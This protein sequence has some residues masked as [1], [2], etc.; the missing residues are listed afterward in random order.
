MSLKFCRKSMRIN[1]IEII[2]LGSNEHD[3]PYNDNLC[4]FRATAVHFLGSVHVE[5]H[6]TKIFHIFFYCKRL[7]T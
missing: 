4:F 5:L 6:A 3:E 1:D 7:R 2:C